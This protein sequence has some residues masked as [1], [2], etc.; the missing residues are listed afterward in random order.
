[1]M[2]TKAQ[3]AMMDQMSQ[4]SMQDMKDMP[5]GKMCDDC[6]DKMAK[7]EQQ[8]NKCSD[9]A[10]CVAKCV[11]VTSLIFPASQN[12][13]VIPSVTIKT[14]AF[15]NDG[16]ASDFLATQDRPPKTTLIG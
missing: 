16:L 2:S 7:Q 10:G 6:A 5:Q 12:L 11:S 13:S 8:K 9:D 14:F 4:M 3:A 15:T 1:M